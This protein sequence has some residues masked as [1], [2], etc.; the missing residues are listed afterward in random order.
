MRCFPTCDRSPPLP[1]PNPHQ[2]CFSREYHNSTKILATT[3]DCKFSQEI[4]EN[5]AGTKVPKRSWR[6]S[7]DEAGRVDGRVGAR[8]PQVWCKES[9][10]PFN[11]HTAIQTDN[12]RL[13]PYR[14]A[15]YYTPIRS[16]AKILM[17]SLFLFI[18]PGLVR[19]LLCV[20]RRSF[21]REVGGWVP[22]G[23]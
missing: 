15:H 23:G 22:L 11:G 14:P 2:K 1:N 21:G 6:W 18:H 10:E 9:P 5:N 3:Y 4:Q 7:W 19:C 17:P 20:F 12:H 16:R 8:G 13:P